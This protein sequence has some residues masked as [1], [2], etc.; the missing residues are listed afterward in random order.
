[1]DNSKLCPSCNQTK[2]LESFRK[3]QSK[4]LGVSSYCR[5]CLSEIA[6]TRRPFRTGNQ[7]ARDR[8]NSK[9][10]YSKNK[11]NNSATTKAYL[12]KNP[13]L[14]SHYVATYKARKRDNGVFLISKVEI[15]YLLNRPCFYCG[16]KVQ[17]ITLDHVIPISK[18]GRHS[19]GNLV[20]ACMPCNASKG[21]K[22]ITQWKRDKSCH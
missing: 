10:W 8:I 16:L 11:P 22:F 13:G 20:A 6:K 2:P 9:N 21:N 19:I 1:M 17:K 18:G 3:N 12:D 5:A 7:R 15:S 4:K 14:R